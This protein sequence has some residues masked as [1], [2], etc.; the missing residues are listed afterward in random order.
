MY[1]L[2]VWSRHFQPPVTEGFY[3]LTSPFCSK[4]SNCSTRFRRVPLSHGSAGQLCRQSCCPASKWCDPPSSWG[5]CCQRCSQPKFTCLYRLICLQ[6]G[7]WHTSS[8]S[9]NIQYARQSA[10]ILCTH[11]MQM[12]KQ[13]TAVMQHA[14]P[15][16]AG[17]SSVQD[18]VGV[19]MRTCQA[20]CSRWHHP[21]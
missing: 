4:S 9:S 8:T 17:E 2:C 7:S 1:R 16:Q 13:Q 10:R 5:D 18:S 19:L 11:R 12:H 20:S 3:S 21:C 14:R 15:A 6:H